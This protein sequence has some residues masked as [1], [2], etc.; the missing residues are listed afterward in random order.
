MACSGTG[1]G[2]AYRGPAGITSP[3]WVTPTSSASS[4]SF[5][6]WNF[7]NLLPLGSRRSLPRAPVAAATSAGI[8]C[9]GWKLR[10]AVQ[11]AL[12]APFPQESL[13]GQTLR[14][15]GPSASR[16]LYCWRQCQALLD[17]ATPWVAVEAEGSG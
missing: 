16:Y 12:C 14:A 17:H 7:W 11:A 1:Q 4:C 3:P 6:S 5:S 10:P 13:S 8:V 9:S 2:V 15:C